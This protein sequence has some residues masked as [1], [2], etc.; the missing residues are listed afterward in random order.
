MLPM[1]CCMYVSELLW[2]E[3]RQIFTKSQILLL[4]YS[5]SKT[6]TSLVEC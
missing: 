3:T 6:T 2:L 1:H 5:N 4:S